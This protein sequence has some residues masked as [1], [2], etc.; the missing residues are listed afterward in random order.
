MDVRLIIKKHISVILTFDFDT[1][2]F[3]SL[4]RLL[5]FFIGDFGLMFLGH[6]RR[7][8]YIFSKRSDSCNSLAQR[9]EQM[10]FLLCSSLGVRYFG[11]IL[12]VFLHIQILVII[13]LSFSAHAVVFFFLSLSPSAL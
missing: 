13:N 1:D 9:S 6:I 10:P 2:A 12:E 3:H 5:D 11:T 4:Q 7:Q 8:V